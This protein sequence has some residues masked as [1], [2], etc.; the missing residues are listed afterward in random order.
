MTAQEDLGAGRR[1]D[2]AGVQRPRR[3][4]TG[5]GVSGATELR[6]GQGLAVNQLRGMRTPPGNSGD[7]IRA[8]DAMRGGEGDSARRCSPVCG[9]LAVPG[10]MTHAS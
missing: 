10:A 8:R 7:G 5:E 1:R 9:A 3:R 6:L 4:I 2:V